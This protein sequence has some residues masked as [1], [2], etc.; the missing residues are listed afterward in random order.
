MNF[1]CKELSHNRAT[2]NANCF[3]DRHACTQVQCAFPIV[4]AALPIHGTRASPSRS[5]TRL[6]LNSGHLS[7]DLTGRGGD[8][9]IH[10]EVSGG[11]K[12]EWFPC[13]FESG[14]GT[15]MTLWQNLRYTF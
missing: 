9:K 15:M 7:G 2:A 8:E 10:W 13:P 1:Q 12:G 5:R 4:G 11:A 6:W 14:V 3:P